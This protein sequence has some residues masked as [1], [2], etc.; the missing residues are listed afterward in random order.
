MNRPA[1]CWRPPRK[2]ILLSRGSRGV[3]LTAPCP[4]CGSKLEEANSLLF[5][6]HCGKF[7]GKVAKTGEPPVVG[8]VA[9]QFGRL[10]FAPAPAVVAA[11]DALK[12][13]REFEK[14]ERFREA[15]QLYE[16]LGLDDDLRRMKSAIERT[17]RG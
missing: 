7:V 3:P 14:R 10:E 17:P 16:H 11:N 6:D 4:N 5:C 8:E 9:S 12:R 2:A 15:A 1:R 13:A